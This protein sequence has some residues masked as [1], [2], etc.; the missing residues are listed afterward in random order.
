MS[1]WQRL[2]ERIKEDWEAK[3]ALALIG[4]GIGLLV[5]HFLIVTAK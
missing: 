4:L 3:L 1:F 5:G 2:K